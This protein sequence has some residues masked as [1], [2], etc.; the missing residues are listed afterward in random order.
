MLDQTYVPI[1][2]FPKLTQKIKN[3]AYAYYYGH[4]GNKVLENYSKKIHKLKTVHKHLW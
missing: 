4:L 1:K 3:D 2:E